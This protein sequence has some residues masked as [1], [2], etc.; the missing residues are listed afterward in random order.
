[1]RPRSSRRVSEARV[2]RRESSGAVTCASAAIAAAAVL[3]LAGAGCEGRSGSVVKSRT[4]DPLT[5]PAVY[6][7]DLGRGVGE[8]ASAGLFGPAPGG[9]HADLVQ[10]LT[11][12]DDDEDRKGLFVRL[13]G[14]SLPLARAEEIGRLLG[15]LKSRGLP[16]VCHADALG[17]GSLLLAAR[18]CSEVWLSPAGGV[19]SVGL[20]AQ[21]VFAKGLL[22]KLGV[23]VDFLQVGK[24]KG[25]SEPYTREGP[26]PEARESLEGTLRDLRRAWI[27]GIE[28]GRGRELAVALEDGP[29]TPQAAKELGLI[30]SIGYV[31][32]ALEAAKKASN[33][34]RSERGFGGKARASGGLTQ[35]LR[36]LSGASAGGGHVAVVRAVGPITM[37][38]SGGLFGGGEGITESGLGRILRDLR[39]D[40]DVRAVVL[41]IDSPGG[42]ALASDLLWHELMKLRED[43]PLIVSVGGMAASGGYYL[44][45]AGNKIYAEPSSIVG[46]I[47]V[48]G[49]KFA[50]GEPLAQLGVQTVTI[51]ANPDPARAARSTYMSPF[52]RWDDATRVK[53]Q[54]SMTGIYDTFLLRIVEGRGLERAIVER[55][56]EGRIFGGATAKE[57]QLVDELGGLDEA[58][59]HALEVSGLGESGE[60]RL[61][62]SGGGLSELFGGGETD[63]GEGRAEA[64]AMASRALGV[65]ALGRLALGQ[66]LGEETRTWLESLAPMIQGEAVVA[67]TPFGVWLR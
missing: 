36:A 7:I 65:D 10:V 6:E 1:M 32:E 18:G 60:V 50:V 22:D 17:H 61:V 9:T 19:E 15:Q 46:S 52:D 28:A 39:D 55:S 29:H 25:A 53:V 3:V 43:K 44:A 24:F 11:S 27:D 64:G 21:L 33:A 58:M 41:R 16:V 14:V 5:G 66:L 8:Q 67:S 38:P 49:G 56:A 40:D 59:R 26:S 35:I 31:D 51:A 42:S 2:R 30:D 23:G 45:C 62:E 13:G 34:K 63:G 20:A 57:R 54:A 37:R 47:G 12:V 48:V 4:R